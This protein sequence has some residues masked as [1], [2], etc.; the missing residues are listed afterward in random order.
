VV[1]GANTLRRRLRL[2]R[3]LRAKPG[4]P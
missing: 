4:A 2:W 3:N 1:A